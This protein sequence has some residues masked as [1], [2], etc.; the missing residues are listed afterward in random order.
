MSE[1]NKPVNP[2]ERR[3]DLI[4]SL[5][6]LNQLMDSKLKKIQ[7][8]VKLQ[9]FRKGK[10]PLSMVRQMHGQQAYGEAFNS[11]IQQAFSEKIKDEPFRVVAAPMVEPKQSEDEKHLH[12]TAI[13]EVFPEFELADLSDVAITRP[14]FEVSDKEV[15]KT[16]SILQK[17]RV[18]YEVVE[19]AAQKEDR[20]F[21]DFLGTKEGEPF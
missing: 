21:V 6:E 7:P 11:L 10:V 1:E 14:V 15:D 8:N 13:F 5:E 20:V 19:R 3:V 4:V 2:L 18:K 12:C 9:G 16:L 17:Q